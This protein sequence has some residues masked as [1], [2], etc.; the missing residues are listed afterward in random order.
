MVESQ[1]DEGIV[2]I[3]RLI[4]ARQDNDNALRVDSFD[5]PKCIHHHH[6]P[7]GNAIIGCL[8]D[9]QD[10]I[11]T[12]RT[13]LALTFFENQVQ[14]GDRVGSPMPGT[15]TIVIGQSACL[16]RKGLFSTMFMLLVTPSV[17]LLAVKVALDPCRRSP[18]TMLETVD[19]PTPGTP[20]GRIVNGCF[21]DIAYD[22]LV[23]YYFN[24]HRFKASKIAVTDSSSTRNLT[25][26]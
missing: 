2:N 20:T 21:I 18:I 19:L 7:K 11:D 3:R 13:E 17:D 6:F 14:P 1:L 23:L 22:V 9:E 8:Q 16:P 4:A 25:G 10:N 5:Q 26:H 24:P 15:S 12:L